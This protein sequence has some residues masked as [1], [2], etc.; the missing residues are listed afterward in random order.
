MT[1]FR[2]DSMRHVGMNRADIKE[3]VK[4]KLT[5]GE[6]YRYK[7]GRDSSEDKRYN[8]FVSCKLLSF[9]RNAAVFEESDGRIETLTYQ[10]IWTMLLEGNFK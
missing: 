5:I 2:T 10:D 7:S 6:Q 3:N 1:G 9:S 4:G 8:K